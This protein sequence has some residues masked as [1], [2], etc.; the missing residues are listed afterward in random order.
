MKV[1]NRAKDFERK[2]AACLGNSRDLD[3][4]E[5]MSGEAPIQV[6]L[7]ATDWQLP[8]A[9]SS[10]DVALIVGCV[11]IFID[12]V[13]G[14]ARQASIDAIASGKNGVVAVI[15]SMRVGVRGM[16]LISMAATLRDLN[17]EGIVVAHGARSLFQYLGKDTVASTVNRQQAKVA[18][19]IEDF[20]LK[21]CFSNATAD[22]W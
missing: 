13:V 8:C 20:S 7:T 11:A 4:F 1:I 10:E 15:E 3:S 9:V 16:K 21:I 18:T 17:L 6:G 14:I 2:A 19:V 22:I 12:Q 5:N